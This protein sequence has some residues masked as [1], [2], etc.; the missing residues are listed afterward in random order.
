MIYMLEV[1]MLVAAIVFGLAFAFML[2]LFAWTEG[3]KYARTLFAMRRVVM[4]HR[5]PLAI[6]RVNSRNHSRN[7]LHRLNSN[8]LPSGRSIA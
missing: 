3:M 7:S 2:V 6:S 4:S 1:N 8:R 5:E